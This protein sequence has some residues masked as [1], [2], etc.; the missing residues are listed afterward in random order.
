[1]YQRLMI[2]GGAM[3]RMDKPCREG[4][5]MSKKKYIVKVLNRSNSDGTVLS[6]YAQK[7]Y[8]QEE[9]IT[10]CLK[11]NIT[12]KK[13]ILSVK[14]QVVRDR[15][16]DCIYDGVDPTDGDLDCNA[17]RKYWRDADFEDDKIEEFFEHFL[18]GKADI[19]ELYDYAT[20]H[21]EFVRN[22]IPDIGTATVYEYLGVFDDLRH[23]VL[24]YL[25]RDL[26]ADESAG[27]YY[28]R[29]KAAERAKR[30]AEILWNDDY[31]AIIEPFLELPDIGNYLSYLSFNKGRYEDAVHADYKDMTVISYEDNE[32][33]VITEFEDL[34]MRAVGET[35]G[36]SYQNLL[37][38]AGTINPYSRED[39]AWEMINND[40]FECID[41]QSRLRKKRRE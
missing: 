26:C 20:R 12:Y 30:L 40:Y 13:G 10:C 17:L 24:Y 9:I 2:D 7:P 19:P 34:Y 16:I 14:M 22:H 11:R 18:M 6:K 4:R 21:E 3:G 8:L 29:S 31:R 5:T 33:G 35:K 1:M 28:C 15:I 37:A 25:R 36:E 27:M 41:Y 38:L 39:L 32:C 23:Y